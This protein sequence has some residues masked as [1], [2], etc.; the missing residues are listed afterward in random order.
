[1]SL[2]HGICSDWWAKYLIG[3]YDSCSCHLVQ[4][5]PA[6]ANTKS[7]QRHWLLWGSSGYKNQNSKTDCYLFL[8]FKFVVA[9]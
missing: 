9:V 3:R 1:M 2:K 8:Y 4:G 7:D 6:A 5:K